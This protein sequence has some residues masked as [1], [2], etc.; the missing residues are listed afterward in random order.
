MEYLLKG[1]VSGPCALIPMAIII[2]VWPAEFHAR[3]AH[4]PSL[5]RLDFLGALLMCTGSVLLVFMLFMG[6]ARTY[7]WT[8]APVIIALTLVGI[9]WIGLIAWEWRLSRHFVPFKSTVPHFPFRLMSDRVMLS[10]FM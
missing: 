4:S 3:N 5:K 8:S 7:P 1:K 10:G 2:F 9:S 6:A